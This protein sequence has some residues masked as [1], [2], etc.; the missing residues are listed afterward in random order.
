MRISDWSSDVCSSDLR[1]GER[2]E[3]GHGTATDGALHRPTAEKGTSNRADPADFAAAK[4]ADAAAAGEHAADPAEQAAIAAG[5]PSRGI[6]T[7]EAAQ[8]ISQASLSIEAAQ[9]IWS[10]RVFKACPGGR[11]HAASQQLPDDIIEA[12]WIA[13]LADRK[14]QRP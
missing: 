13:P 7:E 4:A 2:S 11:R 8:H 3:E 9:S 1:D 6:A 14:S 10:R 12:H 5:R